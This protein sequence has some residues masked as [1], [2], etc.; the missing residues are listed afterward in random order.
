MHFG[1]VR[2]TMSFA[3]LAPRVF[4]NQYVQ[5]ESLVQVEDISSQTP[6]VVVAWRAWWVDFVRQL[7]CSM[8]T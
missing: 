4:L 8:V 1:A 6:S 7:A 3:K 5:W 2:P